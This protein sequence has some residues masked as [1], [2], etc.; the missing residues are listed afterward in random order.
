MKNVLNTHHFQIRLRG[1][2]G[3]FAQGRLQAKLKRKLDE[4]D[5]DIFNRRESILRLVK[6]QANPPCDLLGIL[7][8]GFEP[9]YRRPGLTKDLK[10]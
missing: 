1:A 6:W 10:A 7:R 5:S 4:R 3:H 8:R 2:D 9:R